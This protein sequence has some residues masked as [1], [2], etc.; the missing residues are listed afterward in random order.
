MVPLFIHTP[1][2]R[3]QPRQHCFSKLHVYALGRLVSVTRG[4]EGAINI[5]GV[6]RMLWNMGGESKNFAPLRKRLQLKTCLFWSSTFMRE[7]L[8][9]VQ[10][11]MADSR[12]AGDSPARRLCSDGRIE[13]RSATVGTRTLSLVSDLAQKVM[14]PRNI[15]LFLDAFWR[16]P[17]NHT[18]NSPA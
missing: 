8:K 9:E 15:G 14:A 16:T 10:R 11:G 4:T 2:G 3:C 17:V 13:L 12:S 7:R 18:Q 1:S 6:L 5:N